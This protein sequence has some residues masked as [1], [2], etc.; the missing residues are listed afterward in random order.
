M[1][2]TV[3]TSYAPKPAKPARLD[4][5]V[6]LPDPDPLPQ[7]PPPDWRAVPIPERMADL[8]RDRRG[9]P[10]F[11]TVQPPGGVPD[12]GKVD[13]RVLNLE[14]HVRAAREGMCAICAKPLDYW[15]WFIGGPMCVENRVFGDGA[16]HEECARYALA[17]CPYLTNARRDYVHKASDEGVYYGDPNVIRQKPQRV[18]L[19][20]CR[21]AKPVPAGM[22]KPVHRVGRAKRV[23]WYTTAG[24][25]VCA[26]RPE[27]YRQ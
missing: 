18:V 9:Y 8:P 17:V 2:A 12:D 22:G 13:F 14:H 10:V 25:Y 20:V 16:C 5:G 1:P 24:E 6:R 15:L 3:R 4:H 26:T 7:P 11:Y 19:Y 27:T 21:E 23:E